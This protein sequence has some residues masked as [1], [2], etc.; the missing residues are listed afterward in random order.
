MKQCDQQAVLL[1]VAIGVA[2]LVGFSIGDRLA[3]LL[4][5]ATAVKPPVTTYPGWP[6]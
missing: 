6:I 2:I 1:M 4:R 3:P 5:S